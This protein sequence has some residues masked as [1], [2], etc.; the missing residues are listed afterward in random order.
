MER[1]TSRNTTG[2][3]TAQYRPV[4]PAWAKTLLLRNILVNP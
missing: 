3:A 1:A 2:N 4:I